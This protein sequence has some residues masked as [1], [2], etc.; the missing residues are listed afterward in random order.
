MAISEVAS[1]AKAAA[2]ENTAYAIRL[3]WNMVLRP[4]RSAS[5]DSSSAPTN[6]PAKVA[7]MSSALSV[8]VA[9]QS[10]GSSGTSR[11]PKAISKKLKKAPS[12]TTASTRRCQRP[13]GS[14][15]R[16]AAITAC[17]CWVMFRSCKLSGACG[18]SV[19]APSRVTG[20]G[21]RPGQGEEGGRQPVPD[22]LWRCA[23]RDL[24]D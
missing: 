5:P 12:A 9:V 1:W 7:P 2:T 4:Y 14:A 15:S 23:K 19:M 11:L 13:T 8:V 3:S 20:E 6:S 18:M 16:R 22:C 17:T 24:R 10:A 21:R